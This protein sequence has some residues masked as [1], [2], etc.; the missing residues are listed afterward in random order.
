MLQAH[1]YNFKD[2]IETCKKDIEEMMI[3]YQDLTDEFS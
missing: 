2:D 1:L 3:R